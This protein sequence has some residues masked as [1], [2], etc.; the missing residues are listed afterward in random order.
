L[1]KSV[2]LLIKQSDSSVDGAFEITFAWGTQGAII[3][4]Q[5]MKLPII[6]RQRIILNVINDFIFDAFNSFVSDTKINPKNNAKTAKK[7]RTWPSWRTNPDLNTENNMNPVMMKNITRSV[8][9]E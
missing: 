5:V 3:H 8:F 7:I 6:A 2:S 4:M 9:C 1:S